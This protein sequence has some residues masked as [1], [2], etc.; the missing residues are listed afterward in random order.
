[1]TKYEA[2]NRIASRVK[3]DALGDE[4]YDEFAYAKSVSSELFKCIFDGD[5][6]K[7]IGFTGTF[8]GGLSNNSYA[9]IARTIIRRQFTDYYWNIGYNTDSNEKRIS[10]FLN[11]YSYNKYFD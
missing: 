1:M 4:E 8:G 5:T 7:I 11:A 9:I 6:E 2:V 3:Q 10:D